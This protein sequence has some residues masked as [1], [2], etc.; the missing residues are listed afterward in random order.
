MGSPRRRIW[1]SVSSASDACARWWKPTPVTPAP[2]FTT[3][4]RTRW[5]HSP[6]A[7]RSPTTSPWWSWSSAGRPDSHGAANPGP[8][9]AWGPLWG[10]PFRRLFPVARLPIY[11]VFTTLRSAFR[12]HVVVLIVFRAVVIVVV[13]IAAIRANFVQHDSDYVRPQAFQGGD[14]APQRFAVG[15]PGYGHYQHTVHRH[16]HLQR[17]RE[18]Q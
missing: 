17:L 11:F 13:V 7:P 16:C 2:S 8:N 15:A 3:P 18:S 4:F 6:K 12:L 14:R 9:P 10:P 5:L 1:R